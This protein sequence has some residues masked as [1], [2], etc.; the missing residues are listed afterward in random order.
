MSVLRVR[1][2]LAP[3]SSSK[4]SYPDAFNSAVPV[5]AKGTA[6]FQGQQQLVGWRRG[7]WIYFVISVLGQ[8][9]EALNLRTGPL[10]LAQ[11]FVNPSKKVMR[12]GV[13]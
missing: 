12:L 5:I 4:R 6:L 10:I 1:F 13:S 7:R 8:L 2:K 11:P 3:G 9:L